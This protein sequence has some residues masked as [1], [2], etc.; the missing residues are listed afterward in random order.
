[1]S[2]VVRAMN[3]SAG[4]SITTGS[5]S[6]SSGA[7]SVDEIKFQESDLNAVVS[8]KVSVYIKSRK[9]SQGFELTSVRSQ[10][11]STT[12]PSRTLP[13]PNARLET[14][15]LKDEVK[16]CVSECLDRSTYC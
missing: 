10:I 4:S 12:S 15:T 16:L 2:E 7:V 8:V 5:V 13:S 9:H 11:V 1:M 14:R 6:V 3:I